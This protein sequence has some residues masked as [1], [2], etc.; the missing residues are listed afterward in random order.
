M[1][2]ARAVPE[3]GASRTAGAPAIAKTCAGSAPARI[4]PSWTVKDTPVG[5][6]HGADVARSVGPTVTAA[7]NCARTARRL[8]AG[9]DCFGLTCRRQ[10]AGLTYSFICT[11]RQ[12]AISTV[13]RLMP[14]AADISIGLAFRFRLTSFS[15]RAGAAPGIKPLRL[16]VTA[17]PYFAIFKG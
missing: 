1:L 5:C 6:T 9:G 17:A 14:R 2:G 12:I 8:A 15:T 3:C 13:E 11:R 4:T 10:R 16:V 7:S